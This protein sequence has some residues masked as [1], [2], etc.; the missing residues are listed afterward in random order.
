MVD[1]ELYPE[2]PQLHKQV[3]QSNWGLTV[4]TIVLFIAV[5]L[6]IYS[7]RAD[8]V[9]F[10]VFVLLVHEF[11]HFSQM[12]RFNYENVRMLFI[13]LMGAFVQ[14]SKDR[15]SQKESLLV[16]IYGPFP[17]IIL[18]SVGLYLS[19]VYQWDW[20][21]LLSFIFIFVNA[22]N[23]LPI[24]PLDGGQILKLLLIRQRDLYLMVFA[25]I[26]SL[27]LI[28][29]GLLMKDWLVAGFGFLMGIRVRAMQKN[30]QLRKDLNELQV[31]YVVTYEELSN[32]DYH[33]IKQVLIKDKPVLAELDA[34]AE[35]GN[36]VLASHVSDLLI[37][38]IKQDLSRLAK[39]FLFLAWIVLF[40]LPIYLLLTLDFN[41]YFEKL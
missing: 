5:F 16:V 2:K 7:D 23:L 13:P 35:E 41:W 15:Y 28:I 14:G 34:Y 25:L 3:V 21:L 4:F 27:A 26:S 19:G 10:L 6:S 29:I 9:F 36:S 8:F 31:N 11:G 39:V 30:Y 1:F 24:D 33:M 17:G 32:R 12:K 18:G 37:P 40:A 22:I 20:L 38:P